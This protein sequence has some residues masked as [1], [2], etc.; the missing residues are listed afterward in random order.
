M[1]GSKI[2]ALVSPADGGNYEEVV[3]E[4]VGMP[5][6]VEGSVVLPV[7][8]DKTFKHVSFEINEHIKVLERN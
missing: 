1:I 7:Y 3:C 2:V 4:V 8:H 6:G 5:F